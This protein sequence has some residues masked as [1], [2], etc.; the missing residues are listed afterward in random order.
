ML[1]SRTLSIFTGWP[2][3]YFIIW[4]RVT[5][6]LIQVTIREAK[7]PNLDGLYGG[8]ACVR[9]DGLE[10]T[11]YEDSDVDKKYFGV[12]D[13]K[14]ELGACDVQLCP[15]IIDEV[16]Q[17]GSTEKNCISMWTE[18]SPFG[19]CDKDC[20]D[21]GNRKR[22][23]WICFLSLMIKPSVSKFTSVQK[24]CL[25]LWWDEG[26]GWLSTGI[27]KLHQY[28][29]RKRGEIEKIFV[30]KT[31][32]C[33]SFTSNMYVGIQFRTLFRALLVLQIVSLHF[34]FEA[35]FLCLEKHRS[36]RYKSLRTNDFYS[37][38]YGIDLIDVQNFKLKKIVFFLIFLINSG[39]ARWSRWGDWKSDGYACSNGGSLFV[40]IFA[41]IS[42]IYLF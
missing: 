9:E 14:I 12:E 34:Q 36:V 23:R 8:K 30:N 28:H 32:I 4:K 40:Y 10:L 17:Q 20:G 33:I 6:K 3:R 31:N 15:P 18:W 27:Q 29:R 42:V 22:T 26:K 19:K 7:L 11:K 5:I 38:L 24:M 39:T 1:S 13:E 16:S 37:S 35:I 25:R 21:Y 2:P 41:N